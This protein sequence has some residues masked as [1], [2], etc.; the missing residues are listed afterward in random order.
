MGMHDKNRPR[1]GYGSYVKLLLYTIKA[2]LHPAKPPKTSLLPKISTPSHKNHYE[3]IGDIKI[4]VIS[5]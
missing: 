3:K 4:S 5:T 1:A 2:A